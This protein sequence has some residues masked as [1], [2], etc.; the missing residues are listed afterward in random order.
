MLTA[1]CGPSVRHDLGSVPQSAITFD[2]MCHLQD[3]FD[4]RVDAHAQPLR[5][6]D[7]MSTETVREER[8]EHG[9]MR[10]VVLG[11]GTYVIAARSDRV[12][13]R[14]LL[15]DEY[16]RLPHVDI[17][18]TSAEAQ[19]RVRVTW[20]QSGGIRRVRND[21]DVVITRGDETWTLPPQPCVGEFLF[22]ESAYV[23]RRCFHEADRARA[24]GEI[25]SECSV[26][27]P[28]DAST[29]SDAAVP[30]R[31]RDGPHRAR[32][33]GPRR[34]PPHRP[35]RLRRPRPTR[36]FPRPTPHEPGS[37][38]RRGTHL[39]DRAHGLPRGHPRPHPLRGARP[40]GGVDVSRPRDGR[41]LV[42]AR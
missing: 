22:G 38:A 2:D 33:D 1:S 35:P 40:G 7:E 21:G 30:T 29:P 23:M 28:S 6:V 14:S 3:Y 36:A 16:R 4:Q 10:P 41:P 12:R 5:V 9:Q 17:G 8:D 39:C 37:I 24:R 25:P 11:E 32:C 27:I 15:R 20:W 13:F 34:L 42:P 18:L 31:P 19:V 26:T